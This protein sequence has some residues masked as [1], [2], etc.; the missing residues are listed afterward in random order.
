MLLT[1]GVYA[2]DSGMQLTGTVTLD[3]QGDP[4]AV[5]IFKAGST[6]ITASNSSVELVNGASACNVFWQVGSSATLG[7]GTTFVGTVLALTSA[8]LGAGSTVEGRILARNGAVTLD[9]NLVAAPSC[10]APPP[11]PPPAAA[12]AADARRRRA[13]RR[14]VRRAVAHG[15][16]ERLAD[17]YAERFADGY[18]ERLADGYAERIAHGFAHRHRVGFADRLG[19]QLAHG[20]SGRQRFGQ[21]F[22][23]WFGNGSG[24]GQ[25]TVRAQAPARRSLD[26]PTPR[27][28]AGIPRP[29]LLPCRRV[30]VGR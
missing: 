18:A 11:P 14:R 7:T 16:A 17:G 9:N 13:D 5:F 24:S 27:S 28:P 20:H 21:R 23:Q 1:S 2:H 30:T 26:R 19:Q 22:G 25:V 4:A 15:Y 29:E 8:T 12:A 6:L 10:A 3:A